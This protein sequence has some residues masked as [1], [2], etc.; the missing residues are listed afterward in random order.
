MTRLQRAVH[1]TNVA[2]LRTLVA[3][4]AGL[5]KRSEMG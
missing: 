4:F 5:P 3:S 1:V 2:R